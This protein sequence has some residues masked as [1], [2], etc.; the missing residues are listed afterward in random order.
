MWL[1]YKATYILE[2]KIQKSVVWLYVLDNV[3]PISTCQYSALFNNLGQEQYCCR[4]E[5]NIIKSISL[6]ENCCILNENFTEVYKKFSL[7]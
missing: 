6:N 2:K 4:F 3:A 7:F 1:G 5:D